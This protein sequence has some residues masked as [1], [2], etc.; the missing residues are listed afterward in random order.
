MT[1]GHC[2][3]LGHTTAVGLALVIP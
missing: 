1:A 2:A 3:S